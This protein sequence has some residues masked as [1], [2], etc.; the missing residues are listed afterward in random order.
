MSREHRKQGLKLT[1]AQTIARAWG[2]TIGATQW[3]E[4]RMNYKDGTEATAY[5]TDDL[6]DAIGTAERYYDV[7]KQLR[8]AG[9]YANKP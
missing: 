1:T 8:K 4:Y 5:Y 7:R 3:G 6:W 9:L 2:C